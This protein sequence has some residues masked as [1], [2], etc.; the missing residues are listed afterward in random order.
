LKEKCLQF[1][2]VHI[3]ELAE[4]PEFLDL[5]SEVMSEIVKRSTLATKSEID[6]YHLII[7]WRDHHREQVNMASTKHPIQKLF[8]KLAVRQQ[9]ILIVEIS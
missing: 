5:P 9:P 4:F 2:D 1:I 3:A 8:R 7:A 6:V